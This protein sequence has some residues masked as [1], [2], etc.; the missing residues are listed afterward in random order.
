M[1]VES[2]DKLWY[3][4]YIYRARFELVGVNRTYNCKTFLQYLKRLEERLTDQPNAP[5]ASEWQSRLQREIKEVELDSIERY[6]DWRRT[7]TGKGNQAQLR[8][9]ENST[10]VFSN[11]LALLQTLQDIDDDLIIIYT[12]VDNNIPAGYKY[13]AKEP[14]HKYRVY[15]RS[16]NLKS[17]PTF[18]SD[19]I[20]FIKRYQK[21]NTILKP[22]TAL[23]RWLWG[24]VSSWRIQY[25]CK[26]FYIEY[27]NPS[28]YTLIL[29]MFGD[30]LSAMYKLEKRPV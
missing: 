14:A 2:R 22:S 29:L 15:L 6:M 18:R 4:K 13:Y 11:D 8:S 27:D 21:T 28:T 26:H 20:E 12:R 19:L 5:W 9:E 3:G 16:M 23:A 1:K 7:N 25:C 30:M 10:S 17:H 24:R